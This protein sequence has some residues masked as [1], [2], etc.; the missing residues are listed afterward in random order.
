MIMFRLQIQGESTGLKFV[1]VTA[2][3]TLRDAVEDLVALRRDKLSASVLKRVDDKVGWE[4]VPYH[5][6][7]GIAIEFER[8]GRR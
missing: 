1:G 8:M 7:G 6:W 4:T 5:E 2:Y 3:P